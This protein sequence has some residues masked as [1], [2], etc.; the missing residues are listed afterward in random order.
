MKN[1]KTISRRLILIVIVLFVA[2]SSCHKK[3]KLPVSVFNYKESRSC[4][5]GYRNAFVV[6]RFEKDELFLNDS[7]LKV[8]DFCQISDYPHVMSLINGSDTFP[9]F[10]IYKTQIYNKD[11]SKFIDLVLENPL[12]NHSSLREIEGKMKEI[13][14]S[15]C[16]F[17]YADNSGNVVKIQKYFE[18]AFNLYF[19]NKEVNFNSKEYNLV[20]EN[21]YQIIPK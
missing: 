21:E 11:S 16:Y 6:I 8:Q 9:I 2:L 14:N 7:I 5:H 17:M 18:P 1:I 15:N 10:Y 12:K 13:L 3:S 20:M 19:D 4:G